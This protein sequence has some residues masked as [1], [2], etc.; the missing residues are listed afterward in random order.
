MCLIKYKL[1]WIWTEMLIV[2]SKYA[3]YS[4]EYK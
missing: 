3:A 4:V 2:K 1:I